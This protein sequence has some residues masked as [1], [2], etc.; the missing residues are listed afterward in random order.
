MNVRPEH[1]AVLC[2]LG[3]SEQEARFL[4]LVATHS[5]Y[6]TLRQFLDF[7][8]TAKGWNVHQFT[9]KSIR[10][11]HV[12]AA[13]CAYRTS[14]FNLF[15]RKVYGILDRDNLRN[16][17]RLSSELIRTRLL[18]LDF[19]LSH[20]GLDYL[21][22]ETDKVAY[23]REHGVP[24]TAIPGRIYKGIDPNSTTKRC[25]VD[26]FPVF[27][28]ADSDCPSAEPTPTLVYCDSANR[29]LLHYITH[30][31]HYEHFLRR[32]P[33]FQFV[34]AAP[35]AVKLQ[36]AEHF[37]KSLFEEN[38][39]ANVRSIARYFRLR[40][41]WDENKHSLLTRADR[42]HLRYGN[43]RYRDELAES[44][45]QKWAVGGSE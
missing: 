38:S 31:R 27:F 42:D 20:P 24:E 9:S 1:L 32:L 30:L 3:Y 7:T 35:S 40:R 16:R 23:F 45:Y 19:V 2:D 34:Y 6:F 39:V 36:R 29:S 17:R 26:R 11:G 21:E 18:I 22:T 13:T 5:G 43:Q 4:Y 41:L 12:R 14:V 15:S 33:G 25:F 8:G 44:N 37:F 28:S 10:L